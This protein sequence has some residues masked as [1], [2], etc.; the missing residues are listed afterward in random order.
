MRDP[1]KA[2]RQGIEPCRTR[3]GAEA[4]PSTRD[5][6]GRRR[7]APGMRGNPSARC[8]RDRKS[9]ACSGWP[10]ARVIAS[11]TRRTTTES[12]TDGQ[13][14]TSISG[15]TIS[16]SIRLATASKVQLTRTRLR[17][18]GVLSLDDVCWSQSMESNHRARGYEPRLC[19]AR[20]AI[21]LR[22]AQL[23]RT[24]C[25]FGVAVDVSTANFQLG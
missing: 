25:G 8:P 21:S 2:H 11:P 18:A 14:L 17:A 22:G 15:V 3:F 5:V 7:R 4:V 12:S 20:T 9:R 19:P 1:D 16:I 6:D 24:R 10:Q 23:Q 13:T